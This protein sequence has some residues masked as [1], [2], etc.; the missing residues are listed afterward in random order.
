VVAAV[1]AVMLPAWSE[2]GAGK[3]PVT[4]RKTKDNLSFQLPPD[5]PVEKRGGI[6]APIPVEEY[7][8]MKF[9]GVESKLQALEQRLE[10]MDIRLRLLEE[11]LKKQR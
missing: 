6:T 8:A 11:T 10:G 2:D 7:L 1:M 5:W 9:K 3:E 4:V